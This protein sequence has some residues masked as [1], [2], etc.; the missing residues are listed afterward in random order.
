MSVALAVQLSDVVVSYTKGDSVVT[1]IDHLDLDIDRGS[2]VLLLGPSGCGKTTLL[3]CMAGI[4]R[5]T[6][7]T[8]VVDGIDVTSIDDRRLTDFRRRDTG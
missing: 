5:P 7:G 3:S 1:P 4:L 6:S 8:V 2:L